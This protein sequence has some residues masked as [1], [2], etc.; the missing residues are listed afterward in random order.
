MVIGSV[1]QRAGP[2]VNPGGRSL[3]RVNFFSHCTMIVPAE[4]DPLFRTSPFLDAVGPF[5]QHRTA[6]PLVVGLLIADKH[7]NNRGLAH[8]GVFTTLADIAI[9]YATAFSQEPPVGLVTITLNS[10]FIGQ[11]KPGDWITARTTIDRIGSR[12]A[13]AHAAILNGDEQI[14]HVTATFA[15]SK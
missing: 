11:A 15:V 10:Q 14:G 5:Y 9:G 3:L 13:F 12:I 2:M 4:F 6:R 7:L 8:A 1:R